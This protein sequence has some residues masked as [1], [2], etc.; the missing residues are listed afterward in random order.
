MTDQRKDRI[1]P[2]QNWTGRSGMGPD[3]V[4]ESVDLETGRV[5]AR[6]VPTDPEHPIYTTDLNNFYTSFRLK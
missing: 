5:H 3:L 6:Y 1:E 4:V 2:G